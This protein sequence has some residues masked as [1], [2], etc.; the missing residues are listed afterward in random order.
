MGHVISKDG[1]KLDPDKVPAMKNMPKPTSKSEVLIIHGFVNYLINFLPKRSAV[2][3]PKR[4]HNQSSRVY[5]GKTA[6][7]SFHHYSSVGH[8]RPSTDV[9]QRRRRCY[10]PDRCQWQGFRSR[11]ASTWTTCGVRFQIL[12]KT[13]QT[14]GKEFLAIVFG[15]ER[16]SQ[17]L[18]RREKIKAETDHKPLES[19][20]K[21]SLLSAPS[22]L[23]TMLLRLQRYNLAVN[24]KPRS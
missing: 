14:I 19:I 17:Y 15:C 6:W 18:A 5:I 4:A 8:T 3:T 11:T 2:C 9:L 16:F 23:Q 1:L 20:F 10:H 22:R 21:K 13:E 24:Y 7:W 12:S